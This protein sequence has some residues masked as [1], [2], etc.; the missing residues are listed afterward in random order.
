MFLL[1]PST[2][3]LISCT[4]GFP[5]KFV[6]APDSKGFSEAPPAILDALN[7]L[8][9][10]GQDAI[11]DGSYR[12]FNELLCLGYME[13][14]KI[15]VS[16]PIPMRLIFLS[17]TDDLKMHDDGEKDLGPDIASVSLGGAASMD[18]R[19]KAKHWT[20]K[21]LTA[22]NYDPDLWVLPGSQAWKLRA[23]ANDLY[24]AG[25]MDE[26]EAAKAEV[27][28]SLKKDKRKNGATVLTLELRH[29]DMVVMHGEQIQ[30]VYE[31][32]IHFYGTIT[33]LTSFSMA[34]SQK[35]NCGLD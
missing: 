16:L 15:G 35:G 25:R 34:S 6:A 22:Q 4:Q 11:Q 28:S 29:G 19:I 13:N 23:A 12:P 26:Y 20:V 5:Y 32:S 9:W 3:Y 21:G 1:P 33:E 8:T 27:F 10:A 17:A 30:K 18:F 2:F 31:V 7:R 24:K 14:Q